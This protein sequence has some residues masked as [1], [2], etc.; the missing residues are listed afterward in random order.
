MLSVPT[1][2]RFCFIYLPQG[3]SGNLIRRVTAYI[4]NGLIEKTF[5]PG[6][7]KILS[8]FKNNSSANFLTIPWTS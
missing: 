6:A 8:P 1:L 4:C 3:G 2:L 5:F 7:A